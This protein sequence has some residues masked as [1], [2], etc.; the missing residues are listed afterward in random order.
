MAVV[1]TQDSEYAKEMRKWNAIH[2][3]F[4]PPGRPYVFREFPKM[5]YKAERV[6]GQI[7]IVDKQQARDEHEQRN[8]QSRGFHDGQKEAIEA[9][10][11][12][13]TLHGVL[14]AEREYQ[15]QHGRLSQGA[16]AEV[17]QAEAA[18]GARHLPDVPETPI[19][20]HRKRG[21]PSKAAV[22][23]AEG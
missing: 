17:R 2:T 9:I 19:P 22:S 5:L 6:D 14:A 18:H 8:L 13:Q 20:A 3:E 12:E 7:R 16:V 15:V 4:G 10:E 23:A 1:F 11:Q 21:R